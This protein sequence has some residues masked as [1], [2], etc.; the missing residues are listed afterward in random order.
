MAGVRA[1]LDDLVEEAGTAAPADAA[2]AWLA[3]PNLDADTRRALAAAADATGAVPAPAVRVLADVARDADARARASAA[4]V[5]RL[6]RLLASY[7]ELAA[8]SLLQQTGLDTRDRYGP[9]VRPR[10]PSRAPR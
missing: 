1:G 7:S 9:A 4:E 8:T 2:T 10:L 3:D 6:Q 5:A